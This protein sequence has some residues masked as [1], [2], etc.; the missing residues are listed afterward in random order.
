VHTQNRLK[1]LLPEAAPLLI[2][3]IARKASNGTQ[4]YG[5]G[6]REPHD[7][8][9]HLLSILE[10]LGAHDSRDA[11]P[12]TAIEQL[13]EV[14]KKLWHDAQNREKIGSCLQYTFRVLHRLHPD[15]FP[16]PKH[17]RRDHNRIINA[18]DF[19]L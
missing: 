13:R 8:A 10:S 19:G 16:T 18:S 2:E 4:N 11:I 6:P 1:E 3:E 12:E 7:L 9:S 17:D 15:R 5:V 14:Q